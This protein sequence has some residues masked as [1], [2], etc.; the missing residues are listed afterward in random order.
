MAWP[1]IKHVPEVDGRKDYAA[2]IQRAL[3]LGGF[4]ADH[5]EQEI[6]VGF[7]HEAVL[8]AA[9]QI[10]DAVKS[11]AIRRFFLVGGCDG[12]RAGRNYFTKLAEDIPSDCI[13]LTLGCGKNRFNRLDLGTVAGF[14]KLL[15]MGQ[16]NDAYSAIVVAK[17]LAGAFGCSVNDLP[18]SLILSWYEQKAVAVLLTLLWL[19]VKNIR[20]GPTLP[21]FLTPGVTQ[22]LVDKF[23]LAPV[24]TVEHDLAACLG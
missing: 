10:I 5:L 23:Q 13:I 7:G 3:A 19:G 24:T 4:P 9:P 11:G 2:L 18:L 6:T 8:A 21:A 22:A 12:A 1:G 15:D 16:C 20:L 14:P 17:A